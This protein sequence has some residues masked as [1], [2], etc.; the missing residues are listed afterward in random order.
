MLPVWLA[1]GE[2]VVGDNVRETACTVRV[3][4]VGQ[5]LWNLIGR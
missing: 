2:W 3:V 5:S 1:L 4:G